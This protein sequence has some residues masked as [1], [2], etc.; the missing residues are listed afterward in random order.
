M[1]TD[2]LNRANSNEAKAVEPPPNMARTTRPT[3]PSSAQRNEEPE[4][5]NIH[6]VREL[7]FGSQAREFD[8]AHRAASRSA[9]RARPRRCARSSTTGW[10]RS[11]T[12][13][14]RRSGRQ[15]GAARGEG[16][17]RAKADQ[18]AD[19]R[20]RQDQ[21]QPGAGPRGRRASALK[22]SEQKQRESLLQESKKLS[23]EIQQSHLELQSLLESET[24]DLRAVMTPRQR[25]GDLLT[26]I[27]MRLKDEL[28]LPGTD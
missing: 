16:R 12:S 2:G 19:R 10:A 27:G 7:L 22:T 3:A 4:E 20:P 26:E 14:R 18:G 15:R 1:K 11:R 6:K 21:Q 13:S 5:A 23:A 25:L 28:E 8:S 9:W 17:A 24:S